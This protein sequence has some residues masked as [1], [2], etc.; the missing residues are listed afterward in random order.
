[1]LSIC[2]GRWRGIFRPGSYTYNTIIDGLSKEGFLDEALALFSEMVGNSISPDVV[3][4]NSLI[5][6]LAIWVGGKKAQDYSMK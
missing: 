6:D 4:Y 1:M 3:T 5:R 2:L